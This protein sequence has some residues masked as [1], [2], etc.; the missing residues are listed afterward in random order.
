MFTVITVCVIAFLGSYLN[1]TRKDKDKETLKMRRLAW[2]IAI[3]AF[4]S[5]I[6][7]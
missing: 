7:S 1:M 5:L 2:I 6:F 4:I 3:L